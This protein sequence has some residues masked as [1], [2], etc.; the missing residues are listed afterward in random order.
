MLL[1]VLAGCAPF[2]DAAK[3]ST[4]VTKDPAATVRTFLSAVQRDNCSRAFT[5]FAKATQANIRA[6]S[7]KAIRDAPYYAEVFSPENLYCKATY[8]NRYL[9]YVAKSAKL[10][11]QDGDRAVVSVLLRDP[12]DFLIPGFFPTSHKDVPVEMRLVKEVEGWKITLPLVETGRPG[13]ETVEIGDIEVHFSKRGDPRRQRVEAE[14]ILNGF[15]DEVE[16]LLLDP[17]SWPH[18]L[19]LVREA[20]LLNEPDA[21]GRRHV[22]ARL[23][24]EP[25]GTP[26]ELLLRLEPYGR[27]RNPQAPWTTIRW[28]ATPTFLPRVEGAARPTI[29]A[30]EFELRTWHNR[31]HAR[32]GLTLQ[33]DEWPTGFVEQLLSAKSLAGVLTGVEAEA[34]RRAS[35]GSTQE[36]KEGS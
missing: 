34:R 27:P 32:F 22:R 28:N 36:L 21:E 33:P 31:L 15:R 4:A 30:A 20:V 3:D 2:D 11:S 14:G 7:K 10:A 26:V 16:S 29:Y 13:W 35:A 9:S 5:Y 18:F 19:P 12:T 8:T 1:L 24:L 25:E 6:Q 17:S 23:T